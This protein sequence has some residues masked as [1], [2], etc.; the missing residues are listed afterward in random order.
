MIAT[1]APSFEA[2]SS[3]F[4]TAELNAQLIELS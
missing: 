3:L 1:P 4:F 2:A